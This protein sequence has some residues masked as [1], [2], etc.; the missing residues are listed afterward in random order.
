MK[1]IVELAGQ[2][3]LALAEAIERPFTGCKI[4][5]TED[6]MLAVEGVPLCPVTVELDDEE[7]AR[8]FHFLGYRAGLECTEQTNAGGFIRWSGTSLR[9][10]ETRRFVISEDRIGIEGTDF[11][12]PIRF[13]LVHVPA[14]PFPQSA[15]L[16]S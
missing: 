14:Y 6:R 15:I 7:Q 11:F 2:E 10:D 1:C 16:T 4:E 9:R 12:F 3:C 13:E 5:A 8:G